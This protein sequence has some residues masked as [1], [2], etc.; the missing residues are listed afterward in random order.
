M[1]AAWLQIVRVATCTRSNLLPICNLFVQDNPTFKDSIAP[2]SNS[3][4]VEGSAAGRLSRVS[5]V[6]T[7]QKSSVTSMNPALEWVCKPGTWAPLAGIFVGGFEHCP[8]GCDAG[9][10]GNA[11]NLHIPTC[12]DICPAGFHSVRLSDVHMPMHSKKH[13]LPSLPP[14]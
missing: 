5:V 1:H 10:Y 2:S 9:F 14:N 13:P 8:Y 7:S 12:T 4:Y 3:L 11:T 6:T